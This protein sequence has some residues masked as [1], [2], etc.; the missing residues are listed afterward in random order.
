[1]TGV[2]TIKAGLKQSQFFVNEFLKDLSDSDILVRP[3]PG[4]NHIA[5]QLGHLITAEPS[6]V[7]TAC[8]NATMPELPANFAKQ[9]SKETATQDTGFLTRSE[10]LDQFNKVRTATLEVVGKLTDADLN[11][12]MT[13]RMAD[14]APTAGVM[15]LIVAS[16]PTMHIGQFSVVRRKLNKPHVM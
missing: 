9:H 1:M 15:L 5:W 3:V 7:K 10:Y 6:M 8:P 2:D 13:G 14:F 16:H 4:A 11:R 12:P